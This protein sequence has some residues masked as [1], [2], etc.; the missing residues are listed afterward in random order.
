M[1]VINTNVN[2]L[3]SQAA[4]KKNEREM[5]IAM[6]RLSTGK[7][8]NSAKDDAAGMA[9]S[10]RMTSQIRGLDQAVK[11]LAYCLVMML[12]KQQVFLGLELLALFP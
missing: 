3:L 9:I 4:L 5:T 1:T 7:R 11:D 2:A 8:I 12:E 10:Q 6:E